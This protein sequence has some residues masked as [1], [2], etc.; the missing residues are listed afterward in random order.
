VVEPSLT[1]IAAVADNGAI[2]DGS[3]L[4]W[5][6]PEDFA[7]FKR[8]TMGGVLIQGRTTFQ[9][10][11]GALKGRVAIVV[12]R[13]PGS[14]PVGWAADLA[15]AAALAG[16]AESGSLTPPAAAPAPGA[17]APPA[18]GTAVLAAASPEAAL[19][20]LAQFPARR[21]WS[22]GGGQIYRA[23]WPYTTDLDITQVHRSPDAPVHFPAIDPADW[24]ETGRERREGF[25]FV[26]YAR[27]TPDA[28]HRLAAAVHA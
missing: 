9:S 25:D 14:V 22:I 1:A 18:H 13:H 27:R 15:E 3:G 12:T 16:L 19:A 26:A 11:G 10:M 23:L 6:L 17:P 4:L 7:R 5:H 2:G 21:W 20:L 28:A 8:V 24:A